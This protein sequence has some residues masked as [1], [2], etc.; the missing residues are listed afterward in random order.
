MRQISSVVN[1]SVPVSSPHSPS[2]RLLDPLDDV[3]GLERLA[4]Q[5]AGLQVEQLA[6]D[7]GQR[8]LEVVRALAVAEGVVQLAGLGVDE[9]RRELAGAAP[10][11]H[12][13]Q[14][15]VAPEEPGQVQPHQQHDERVE[16]LG[17]AVVREAVAEQ[18][19]VGQGVLQVPG[20]QR[21]LDLLAV[22]GLAA[23]DHADRL[24][25]GQAEPAQVAQ[26]PVLPVGPLLAGLL[27]GV[28]VLAEPHDPDDVPRDAAGQRHHDVVTPLVERELPGEGDQ[29]RVRLRRDDAQRHGVHPR[30]ADQGARRRGGAESTPSI[31]A[32]A[33]TRPVR[34]HSCVRADSAGF[35]FVRS[36]RLGGQARTWEIA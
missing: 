25:R 15:H 3:V 29:G 17:Q 22:G 6:V 27:H 28:D 21:R 12:V 23:A 30:P 5:P 11:Q 31:R 35:K 14:R 24:D 13:G 7:V 2:Y 34:L 4:E 19:P 9:V 18:R 8:H 33:P 16:D 1:S 20:D 32:F 36:R 10:E 26:Q